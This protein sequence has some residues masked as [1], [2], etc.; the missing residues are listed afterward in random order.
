[1]SAWALWFITICLMVAGLIGTL[2]PY[3]PGLP[4]IFLATALHKFSALTDHPISWLTLSTLAILF[5]MAELVDLT[6][7]FWGAKKSGMNRYGMWGCVIGFICGLPLG[8]PGI[9]AGPLVGLFV[10]QWLLG[11]SS[12]Y[13]ALQTTGSYVAGSIAGAVFKFI[14]AILM[15]FVF[16]WSIWLGA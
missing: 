2:V 5:V 15:I 8:L 11:R 3:L 12:F 1:M 6:S 14:I 9:L 4:L 13:H 16:A 10:G 7:G